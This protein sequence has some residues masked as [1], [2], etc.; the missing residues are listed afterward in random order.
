MSSSQTELSAS[1][2]RTP[3]PAAMGKLR[4]LDLHALYYAARSGGDFYDVVDLGSRVAFLLSDIAGRRE[5]AHVIAAAAQDTFRRRAKYFLSTLDIN[6]MD[7]SSQLAQEINNALIGTANEVHFAPTF[8]GC[9][10]LQLGI[11]AYINAGGQTAVFRDSEGTRVLPNVCAPMGLF[12][13]LTYEP[14]MLAFEPGAELL[15][16]TKGV[17]ESQRGRA[18]FG[19]ERVLELL[20]NSGAD[21]AVEICRATVQAAHDF[22]KL[23]WYSL[24]RLRHRRRE[25]DEDLTALAMVRPANGT[26]A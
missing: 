25:L 4:G 20:Q 16:V 22:R 12:T 8:I 14:S 9:Y 21:S 6:V 13:H 23:P 18:H 10:D 7:G 1:S 19:A 2:R 3:L 24:D 15:V 11:L 17:T 26:V 5:K